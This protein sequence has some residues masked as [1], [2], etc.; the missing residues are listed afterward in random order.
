MIDSIQH[1][2][3]EPVDNGLLIFIGILVWIRFRQ[4]DK[5]MMLLANT[6]DEHR[7]MPPPN[8]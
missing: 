3:K 5:A 4:L 2:L 1:F 6:I 7:A 8:A